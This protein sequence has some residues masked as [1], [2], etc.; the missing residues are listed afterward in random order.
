MDYVAKLDDMSAY[1]A[2][3]PLD[4]VSFHVALSAWHGRTKIGMFHQSVY[5]TD[6]TSLT[7]PG[8]NIFLFVVAWIMF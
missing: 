5:H 8:L 4:E 7:I 3:S 1:V 6:A 2:L